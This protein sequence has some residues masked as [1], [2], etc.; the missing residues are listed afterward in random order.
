MLSTAKHLKAVF[1]S[2]GFGLNPAELVEVNFDVA[3][4]ELRLDG[5]SALDFIRTMFILAKIQ[6]QSF[7]RI[8][9]ATQFNEVQLRVDA[10]RS[11]AVDC[12]FVSDGIELFIN[13]IELCSDEHAYFAIRE[14]L[15][16][17]ESAGL[18]QQEFQNVSVALNT[19]DDREAKVLRGFCELKTDSQIAS[20]VHVSKL[21]VRQALEKVQRLLLLDTRSQLLLKMF[22]LGALAL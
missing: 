1:D 18:D 19:L 3:I 21:Q 9:V 15:P 12:V 5:Q 4:L 17:L 2:D 6:N 7:G 13:K 11:G 22:E 8:L 10:I 14:L 16:T 20:A